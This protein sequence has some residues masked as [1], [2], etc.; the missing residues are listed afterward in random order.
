MAKSINKKDLKETIG[1]VDTCSGKCDFK[2]VPYV[3]L[4][5]FFK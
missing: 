4:S 3:F 1:P 5:E 2:W